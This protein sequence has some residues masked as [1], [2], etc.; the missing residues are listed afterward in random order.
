MNVSTRL[1]APR[2]RKKRGKRDKLGESSTGDV[3]A[4]DTQD[5]SDRRSTFSPPLL[6]PASLPAASLSA[7]TSASSSARASPSPHPSP[8]PRSRKGKNREHAHSHSVDTSASGVPEAEVEDV[9]AVGQVSAGGD[10]RRE[11]RELV[12]NH[13][14]A[15]K[16]SRSASSRGELVEGYSDRSAPTGIY[17]KK[18]L[19]VNQCWQ[20]SVLNV[21]TAERMTDDRGHTDE[22]SLTNMMGVTQAL[23]SIFAMDDDKP[24]CIMRGRTRISF[25]VKQPLYLFAVSDWGEPDYVVSCRLGKRIDD[26]SGCT[27]STST[28]RFYLS[29]R[30]HNCHAPSSEEATLIYRDSWRVSSSEFTTD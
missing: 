28:F 17:N 24:R 27:S 21:R 6:S 2:S 9:E 25:L 16:L 7:S 30:H 19:R 12:G 3:D 29:S 20:T 4:H 10:V 15:G 13:K 14:V 23:I 8:R 22:D 1:D 26:S 11:L 18:I 5:P